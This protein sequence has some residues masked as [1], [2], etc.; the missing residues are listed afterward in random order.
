MGQTQFAAGANEN[1]FIEH[2]G[3]KIYAVQSHSFDENTNVTL[4]HGYGSQE[5]IGQ[6]RGAKQYTITIETSIALEYDSDTLPAY[7]LLR[8]PGAEVT[9]YIGNWKTVFSGLTFSSHRETGNLQNFGESLTATA[10]KRQDFFKG[11]PVTFDKANKA[12][13]R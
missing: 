4:Q 10:T 12:L 11:K 5:A 3:K 6:T 8:E 13:G 2:D 7:L 1:V 9:R